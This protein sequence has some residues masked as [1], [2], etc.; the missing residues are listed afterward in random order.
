MGEI[1]IMGLRIA[2]QRAGEGPPLVLLHGYVGDGPAT[3][4]SQLDA[5]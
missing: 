2:Y 4:R 5:L 1:E 3:W